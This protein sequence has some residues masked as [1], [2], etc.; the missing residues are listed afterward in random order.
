MEFYR[1]VQQLYLKGVHVVVLP[2]KGC[3]VRFIEVA[4]LL[5]I[6]DELSDATKIH[7]LKEFL[8]NFDE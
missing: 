3:Q 8:A 7:V 4:S 5:V 2:L 1:L 6:S